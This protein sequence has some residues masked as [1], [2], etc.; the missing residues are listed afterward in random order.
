[1]RFRACIALLLY[2]S[3]C[4]TSAPSPREPAAR[5]PRLANL[6][7][8][9]TLPWTDGGRCA[10][11][12]ASE[13]WPV[14][15]ERCF[16]ALDHDRIEFHDPTGRCAVASAGAAAM[17]LGVCVLA[18]PELVVGAVIVAGVVV[19]GFAIKETLDAYELLGDEPEVVMPAPETRPVSEAKPAPQEPSP[20]QKPKPEPK[21]PDFPPPEPPETSERDR[22]PECMPV[23]VPHRG[24]NNDH[25]KCADRIPYNSF[26]GWDVR[27]NGKDFDALQLAVRTLWE[28]KTDDFDIHSPRSQAFFAKV[29]L[30]EIRRE[31]RLAK[32][33]GYNFVVGVKSAAHKEALE[34]LDKTLTIAVMEWC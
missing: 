2:V 6:Q 20:K 23:P 8:A 1:M 34:K 11:Q 12:E 33:C 21:G 15:A 29:K 4:A 27:V 18:A 10:V 22:R 32:E 14:L 9:A 30:P 17:G 16:H 26:S 5:D 19:V 31:A 13:P 7:R 3:A 25:N 24:G 28:V